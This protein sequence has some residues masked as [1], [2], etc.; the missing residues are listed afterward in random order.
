MFMKTWVKA[1]VSMMNEGE[2]L[3]VALVLNQE[4][5]TPRGCGTRMVLGRDTSCGTI[6]GVWI[7]ACTMQTA[8]DMMGKPGAMIR[9]FDLTSTIV[10]GM[11]MICG[12][13]M[14]IL[15]ESLV[16]DFDNRRFFSDLTD[17]L[18]QR[19][20]GYLITDIQESGNGSCSV[21]RTIHRPDD[22]DTGSIPMPEPVRTIMASG[23]LN[24]N[25]PVVIRHGQNCF[26]IES[27][28]P[29]ETVYLFGAGHVSREAAILS[30]MIGFETVV[31]DDRP[32]FANRERFP[33]A[34]EIRILSSFDCALDGLVIDG[35]GY[36]VILT[37]GHLHDKTV[38][39]LALRKPARY[40]G[41]IGSRKKRD[42]IYRA[43]EREGF[44]GD[45]LSRVHSPIGLS[46]GAQTPAEIAV[47][48]A[49]ELIRVRRER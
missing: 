34:D 46:I 38:L 31:L 22:A 48:I 27:I 15:I 47:S 5:S 40:I 42:A 2:S 49:A 9:S 41:M 32:E 23:T 10:D 11:D 13:H 24:P 26:L 44:S 1:I 14:D 45:D 3:V 7:E 36:I 18:N 8:R 33:E 29:D 30:K 28:A 25:L 12:G 21:R 39:G 43:L 37:R 19:R 6:G 20:D 4:G 17:M 35:K 16:P